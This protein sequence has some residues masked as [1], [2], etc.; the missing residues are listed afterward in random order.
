M[1]SE[2]QV[3]FEHFNTVL[4]Q[5]IVDSVSVSRVVTNVSVSRV[6]HTMEVT[7]VLNLMGVA[8]IRDL[9]AVFA[10][11]VPLGG[12]ECSFKVQG[13]DRTPTAYHLTAKVGEIK[14]CY[15]VSWSEGAAQGSEELRVL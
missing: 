6:V 7:W 13:V 2:E 8:R 12:A 10:E 11:C 9:V 14:C 15:A 1:K 4:V 5:W 3:I